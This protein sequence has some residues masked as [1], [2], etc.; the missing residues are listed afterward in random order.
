MTINVTH[1]TLHTLY[2]GYSSTSFE[3]MTLEVKTITYSNRERHDADDRLRVGP[4]PV[5]DSLQSFSAASD[6]RRLICLF[7][8]IRYR[9]HRTRRRNRMTAIA[10]RD[11]MTRIVPPEFSWTRWTPP[12]GQATNRRKDS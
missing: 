4:R 6:P 1:H 12:G 7:G 2:N 8:D 10:E 3:T 9:G 5:V 11:R